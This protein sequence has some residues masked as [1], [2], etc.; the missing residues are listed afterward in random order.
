LEV[1]TIVGVPVIAPVDASNENPAGNVPTATAQAYGVVP[2]VA[3]NVAEYAELT[4][5]AGN[6]VVVTESGGLTA[7]ENAR[8][9]VCDPLSVTRTVKFDVP[10][11]DGVPLITPALDRDKPPS[12]VPDSTDQEYGAVPPVA[13]K[14]VAG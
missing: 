13:D 5:P 10:A 9:V 2:P 6:V 4:T 3:A 12:N 1:P 7:I 11:L 8:V 14:V